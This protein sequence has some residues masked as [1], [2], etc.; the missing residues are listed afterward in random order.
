L[1]SKE[2]S[3]PLGIDFDTALGSGRLA[4]DVSVFGELIAYASAPNL[5]SSLVDPSMSVKRKVTVPVERSGLTRRDRPPAGEP[6][7][8]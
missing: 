7:S 3:V 8:T 2:E 4:D 1:G 5:C 6:L